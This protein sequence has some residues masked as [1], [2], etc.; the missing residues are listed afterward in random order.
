MALIIRYCNKNELFRKISET[1]NYRVHNI[2]TWKNK[3]KLLHNYE[4]CI[5]GK[6]GFTAKAKRT[7]SVATGKPIL[8]ILIV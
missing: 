7:F 1:K 5:G 6:T 3:N 2:G 4:Y 8:K